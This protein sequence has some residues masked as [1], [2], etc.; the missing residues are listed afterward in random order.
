[1]TFSLKDSTRKW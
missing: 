1:M